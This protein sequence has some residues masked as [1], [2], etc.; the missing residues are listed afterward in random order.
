L[1]DVPCTSLA[2]ADRFGHCLGTKFT[3]AWQH[4][5]IPLVVVLVHREAFVEVIDAHFTA[6]PF[7]Q[8]VRLFPDEDY[9]P[10]LNPGSARNATDT[11]NAALNYLY[12]HWRP[13]P[14]RPPWRWVS[15]PALGFFMQT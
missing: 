14:V 4:D 3:K 9:A 7:L 15:I 12:R 5:P 6:S 2:N 1:Q 8:P 11:L 10:A 13:R